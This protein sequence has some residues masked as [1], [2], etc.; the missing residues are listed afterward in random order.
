MTSCQKRAS[1]IMPDELRL[2][3]RDKFRQAKALVEMNKRCP[4]CANDIQ[5][6]MVWHLLGGLELH[7]VSDASEVGYGVVCYMRIPTDCRTHCYFILVKTSVA[8]LKGSSYC[9]TT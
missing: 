1:K 2:G 5:S 3:Q 8:P 4:S 9:A 6:A 7:C